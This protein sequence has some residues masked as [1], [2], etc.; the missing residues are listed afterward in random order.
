MTTRLDTSR[1]SGYTLPLSPS[2]RAAMIAPPPWHF[3][4]TFIWVDY[5]VDP[6]RAARFLP[7]DM[8]PSET[9]AAAA[10]FSSWQWC[11]DGGS[12]LEEPA[13]SQ[14][15]EFMVLLS[16]TYRGRA[17]ARC[18]YAWVDQPVPMIRGW[19][20]G[21]PKQFGSVHMTQS[22]SAGRAG[23]RR[24]PGGVYRGSLAVHDHRVADA[25]VR[26]TTPVA[27]PPVLNTV[28]LVHTRVF[29]PWLPQA[30]GVYE[31]VASDVTGAEYS[32]IWKGEA[33]LRFGRQL[34]D[35]PDFAALAPVRIGP[36]YV[37]DYGETLIGG[38]DATTWE[39][40]HE[41]NSSPR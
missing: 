17:A 22:V 39:H 36:G 21:M 33:D 30:P 20:Q 13:Y 16:V 12:E 8:T 37:F 25:R 23:P 40:A 41:R 27:E 9:G 32:A 5:V 11:T 28:P 14:F 7:P 19:I 10:A 24:Q 29:P 38:L 4:G 31:T 34:L 6:E 15:C 18:P 3:S 26:L 35:D 1:L 2:G